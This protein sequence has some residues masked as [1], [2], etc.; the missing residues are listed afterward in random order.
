MLCCNLAVRASANSEAAC[1][2][3][4]NR[5]MGTRSSLC[6]IIWRPGTRNC[7]ICRAVHH[8]APGVDQHTAELQPL[9]ADCRSDTLSQMAPHAPEIS[10]LGPPSLSGASVT[11]LQSMTARAASFR[12]GSMHDAMTPPSP[13]PSIDRFSS[14]SSWGAS[15]SSPGSCHGSYSSPL[16]NTTAGD[17]HQHHVCQ[18]NN[19]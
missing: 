19:W 5:C 6:I 9:C 15:S 7:L 18:T 17:L 10:L 1:Q 2:W 16:A 14:M 3:S 8:H 4:R 13:V 11:M 12:A